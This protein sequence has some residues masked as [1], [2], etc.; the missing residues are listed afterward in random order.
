MSR[1]A[2]QSRCLF[3]ASFGILY[4][5]AAQPLQLFMLGRFGSV[6]QMKQHGSGPNAYQTWQMVFQSSA[7][8]LSKGRRSKAFDGKGE[9]EGSHSTECSLRFHES[10]TCACCTKVPCDSMRGPVRVLF[11][12]PR[13]EEMK[14]Y[15]TTDSSELTA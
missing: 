6:W 14:S 7:P 4:H 15:K 11:V 13:H 9:G 5:V 1:N 10:R 3:K 12:C 2:Y 8:S